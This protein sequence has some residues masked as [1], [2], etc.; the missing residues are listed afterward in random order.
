[1]KSAITKSAA[2][3]MEK[4]KTVLPDWFDESNEEIKRIL[5]NKKEAHIMYLT[6]PTKENG[7]KLQK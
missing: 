7:K 3:T 4:K 5:D 6:L 1:M 2:E